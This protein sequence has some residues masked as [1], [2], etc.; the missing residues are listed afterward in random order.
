MR[1]AV[2]IVHTTG[3]TLRGYRR[4]RL[5]HRHGR[6]ADPAG[7]PDRTRATSPSPP[8][9]GH[10]RRLGGR[11]DRRPGIDD[12][13]AAGASA[14]RPGPSA[15]WRQLTTSL[16][17]QLQSL[18]SAASVQDSVVAAADDALQS[19]AG[20]N[21]DEEMTNMM[22]YQRA[23]QASARVITTID[24]M[25]DT[26]INRTGVGD[27]DVRQPDH[28][29]Q[30]SRHHAAR[31]AGQPHEHRRSC[32]TSCPAAS[33]SRAERRP[34]GHGVGHDLPRRSRLGRRAVPAQHRRFA[35]AGSASTD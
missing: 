27:A 25:L 31:S 12:T 23:Y 11:H 24:E 33:G 16:G 17:V 15:Q 35:Q 8:R 18:Q 13:A 1:D 6:H 34:V 2:N 19:N 9:A 7:G 29:A 30:L 21:L 10:R 5:L 28:P 22:L 3:F 14:A 20:V 4:H 26:L 32:R